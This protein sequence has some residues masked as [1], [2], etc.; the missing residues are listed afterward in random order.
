[1][2]VWDLFYKRM[3]SIAEQLVLFFPYFLTAVL[4]IALVY[5]F[6]KLA[7]YTIDKSLSKTRMRRTLIELLRKL[8][9][10]FAWIF[11]FLTAA[12]IMFPSITPGNV[13]A[14][15]GL[16]SIAIGLAF[17]DIFENFFAGILILSREPF[18]L[19]DYI[20]CEGQT[21]RVE[22]I[23]IRDT[24][25]RCSNGERIVLPNAFLF[26]N[27]VQIITDKIL[28]RAEIK[29]RIAYQ[30]SIEQAREIIKKAIHE[31]KSV[32]FEHE[33]D[34]Y[35]TKL[36]DSSIELQINWWTYSRPRDTR[37]SID[38]VI[39]RIKKLLDEANISI[40]FPQRT[41]TFAQ[42]IPITRE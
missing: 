4:F 37:K 27:P 24:H 36:G 3:E 35:V 10:V 29:I 40:P 38:E 8:V 32:S 34:V 31:C 15:L 17:K 1:M 23:S 12:A 9:G 13:L 33:I 26:T 28:R 20:E 5:F 6:T 14:A 18:R 2:N 42:P 7:S 41:L 39:T 11:G 16:T 21:G 30:Q 19:G 22:F 25:I